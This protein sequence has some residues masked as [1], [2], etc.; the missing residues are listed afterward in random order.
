MNTPTVAPHV[1]SLSELT[2]IEGEDDA[3]IVALQNSAIDALQKNDLPGAQ[4][5]VAE[6]LEYLVEHEAAPSPKNDALLDL[7]LVAT[8]LTAAPSP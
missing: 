1:I 4:T 2:L 6:L 7:V 5:K 8:R 3:R